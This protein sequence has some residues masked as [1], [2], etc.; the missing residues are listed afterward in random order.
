MVGTVVSSSAEADGDVHLQI[1]LDP[2]YQGV[3]RPGNPDPLLGGL[4]GVGEH[5]WMEGRYILD[6]Q[7]HAWAELH[8]LYRWGAINQ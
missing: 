4:P 5:V 3:L 1:R 6:S 2:P 7:H 8:P